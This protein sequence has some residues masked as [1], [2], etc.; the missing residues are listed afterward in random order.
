MQLIT[1]EPDVFI[2]RQ[3]ALTSNNLRMRKRSRDVCSVLEQHSGRFQHQLHF[4]HTRNDLWQFRMSDRGRQ[5]YSALSLPAT[6][7]RYELPNG[8]S[9]TCKRF[10][11]VTH[12]SRTISK[13]TR[14]LP[15]IYD[16]AAAQ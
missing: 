3:T 6:L 4:W 14:F 5:S 1:P 2:R 10:M 7:T 12:I 9:Q 13:L 11:I 15:F 8:R 16:D